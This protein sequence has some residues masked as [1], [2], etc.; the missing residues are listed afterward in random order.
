MD[1]REF[2]D[3]SLEVTP[4]MPDAPATV[5]T[6]LLRAALANIE[7]EHEPESMMPNACRCNQPWPC[8]VRAE[9]YRR[10]AEALGRKKA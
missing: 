5:V 1:D 8:P 9:A 7:E 2:L 10:L 4:G 3:L 6:A